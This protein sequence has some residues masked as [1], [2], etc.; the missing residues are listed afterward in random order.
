[1]SHKL[2]STFKPFDRK[3]KNIKFKNEKEKMNKI[4]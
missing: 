1:M 2:F 4:R 3:P